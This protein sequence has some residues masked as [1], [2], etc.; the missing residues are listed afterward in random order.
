MGQAPSVPK[1]GTNIQVIGAGLPRTGTASFSR[2]LEILLDGPVFHGGT[3][4]T[5]GPPVQIKRW[6]AAL[7]LWDLTTAPDSDSDSDKNEPNKKAMLNLISTQLN[8]YAASTDAPGA[9]FTP[10]LME[11]YPNAKVICT[12]RDIEA[13]EKSM[14]QVM[15]YSLL[16]FLRGLLLPLP[17]M[18]H[19][20]SYLNLLGVQW[21][22]LYGEKLPTRLT[23]ERHVEWLKSV[24]PEE[25][26]VFFDVKQGWGPL[27][28]ALD[29][30]VPDQPFPH[31]N[32]GEAIDGVA[33]FHIRRG[34]ISWGVILGL[35]VGVLGCVLYR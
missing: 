31:I 30:E 11:L 33:R 14:N 10:E 5:L 9:Q 1:P 24:V 35:G 34:L 22:R 16:W 20:I 7:R 3:Q 27:C 12:V 8:G 25:K 19:F 21:T 15:H 18:R 6:M 4:A 23:Y 17:G 13:W 29:V 32:D 2:A 28:E 26:L